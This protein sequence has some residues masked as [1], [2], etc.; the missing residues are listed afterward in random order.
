VAGFTCFRTTEKEAKCLKSCTPGVDGLCDMPGEITDHILQEGR[1]VDPTMYCFAYAMQDVGSP[2]KQ[3]YEVELLAGQYQ[4]GIGIFACDDWGAWTDKYGELAPGVPLKTVDDVDGDFHFQKRKS[5]G[6]WINAGHF[7]QVWR[8]IKAEQVYKKHS[9]VVKLD[10]DA[11]FVPSRLKPKIA[12]ILVPWGGM[13]LE[14]CRYTNYGF[15]GNLAIYSQ[16][17]FQ[18]LLDSIDDCRST[19][20]WKVGIEGGKYGAMGEDLFAQ[21]CMDSKGVRRGEA[22]DTN[23]DGCCQADRPE[24]QKDNKK[25]VPD[26]M[27]TNTPQYHPLMTPQEFF[28]CYDNT[29]KTF[30]Y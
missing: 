27:S 13:Y 20:P 18:K 21:I 8:H 9:W 10:A 4:K 23:T 16:E 5:S 7:H 14:N 29:I 3:Y 25:W 22:F 2:P 1:K 6:T 11:V 28:A 12:D 30:G 15:F 26:C 19:L 17:A 24:D